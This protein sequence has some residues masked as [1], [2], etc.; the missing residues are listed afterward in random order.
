MRQ[1]LAFWQETIND[2]GAGVNMCIYVA[3]YPA[4]IFGKYLIPV[5]FLYYVN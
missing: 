2:K 5:K 4:V 3:F 1:S